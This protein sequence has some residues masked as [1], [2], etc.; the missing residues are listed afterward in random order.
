MLELFYIPIRGKKKKIYGEAF[1]KTC[2]RNNHNFNHKI[3]FKRLWGSVG[4]LWFFFNFTAE[5]W[6]LSLNQ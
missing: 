3:K 5:I 6:Y 1:V 4:F 2:L